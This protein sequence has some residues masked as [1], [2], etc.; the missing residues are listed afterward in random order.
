MIKV[1]P[2]NEIKNLNQPNKK[3]ITIKLKYSFFPPFN[4]A[5]PSHIDVYLPL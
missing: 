2:E 3:E 4:S 5:T 1:N